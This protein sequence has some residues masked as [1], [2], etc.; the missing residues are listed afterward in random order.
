MDDLYQPT[1]ILEKEDKD[2]I[3]EQKTNLTNKVKGIYEKLQRKDNIDEFLN[4]DE[5]D[6][7]SEEEF[8]GAKSRGK[9]KLFIII[10]FLG[11]L[12]FI[13]HLISIFELNSIINAIE[14][15]LMASA[16]SYLL[17][18]DRESSDDF[19]QN[20]NKINNK[21]PDYS[22]FFLSSFLSKYF[23][24]LIGFYKVMII[25]SIIN[26]LTLYFGFSKFE[27]NLNRNKYE[28]Y[29][30]SQFI[31][32]YI[33]YLVL[34]FSQ[35]IIALVPLDIIKEG[36]IFYD[37]FIEKLKGKI[38]EIIPIKEEEEDNNDDNNSNKKSENLIEN[39][40]NINN[41]NDDNKTKVHSLKYFFLFYLI[42]ITS[43]ILIKILL[44]KTF[45]DEYN[46]S[47]RESVNNFYIVCYT[48]L[49]IIS[50]LL[51]ILY[52]YYILNQEKKNENENAET[53][54][55]KLCG[56]IIYY[57]DKKNENICCCEFCEDCKI[58]CQTLNMSLCCYLCSCLCCLKT[59][60]CCQC[61]R[62]KENND[63]KIRKNNDVNK[64]DRI[65]VFYRVTGRFNWLAKIMT[66][67]RIY[68]L[69][70]M[71]Y[72]VLMT[73][74]GFED[75]IWENFEKHNKNDEFLINLIILGTI[76]GY[77]ILNKSAGKWV[78]NTYDTLKIKESLNSIKCLKGCSGEML[79]IILGLIPY[80]FTQ[81]FISSVLSGIIYFANGEMDYHILSVGI[82]SVEYIKITI[83]EVVSFYIETNY[84]TLE[85]FSSSTIFSIY[86]S[87]W[88]I[89]MFILNLTDVDAIK[90]IFFQFIIG[91]SFTGLFCLFGFFY[92]TIVICKVCCLILFNIGDEESKR[93][94]REMIQ[95]QNS[96]E[97]PNI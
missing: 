63:Y 12:L 21:L 87:V 22:V 83:L 26:I 28:N 50:L 48:S 43:S 47:S 1:E 54:S 62:C 42:C 93:K 11:A 30:L 34:C 8:E 51:Y 13:V 76:L 35:G 64:I 59:I 44:D 78:I 32:L 9:C 46:Y 3:E 49:M 15:E 18:E 97:Q 70:L 96:G 86:L 17:Q 94:L 45:I 55:M 38:E 85:F 37:K 6:Q 10:K 74:I 75:L 66:D 61:K 89:I 82:A 53:S 57:E 91:V 72:F 67:I 33:I 31:S 58:C 4:E 80:I 77:Y 90:I 19:Y 23:I 69:A 41:N 65:I 24:G 71:L 25:T 7:L 81:T 68:P 73:N 39:K 79:E 20:Y 29:S 88:N 16:K 2:L 56:Y 5:D 40:N 60:F 36:F 52:S 27:F 92:F 14:E 95:N 84:K